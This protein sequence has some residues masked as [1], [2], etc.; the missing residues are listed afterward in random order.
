MSFALTNCGMTTG[1]LLP[2][3]KS[4]KLEGCNLMDPTVAGVELNFIAKNK[5]ISFFRHLW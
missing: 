3:D 2:F 1:S 4:V 5:I